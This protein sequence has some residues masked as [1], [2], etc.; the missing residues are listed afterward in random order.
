MLTQ[1]GIVRIIQLEN[2]M[3]NIKTLISDFVNYLKKQDLSENTIKSYQSDLVIFFKWYSETYTEDV[4][5]KITSHHLNFFR[6]QITHE[7]FKTASI[8]RKIQTLRKFF[9]F[10][11][12]KKVIRTNPSKAIKFIRKTKPTSP[13]ALNKQE[14]HALLSGAGNSPHGL[15][16]RNYALVQLM[17]QTGLRVSEVINLQWQDI[18]IYERSGSVRVVDSKGHKERTVPLNSTARKAISSYIQDRELEMITPLFLSKQ[19]ELPTARSIQKLV[20]NLAR[21]AKVTRIKVS[22]HVLRHTFATNYLRTNPECLVELAALLGH[23][24][25]DTTA[26]YTKASP[27][28]LSKTLEDAQFTDDEL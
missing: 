12:V 10:L 21:R 23:E 3:S 14:V 1:E 4:I 13:N 28:R 19:G 20:S 16:S 2:F 9:S 17:L 7:R 15:G 25:L 24:S 8:N 27:E 11:V 6:D 22:P 5:E 18:T 26:I